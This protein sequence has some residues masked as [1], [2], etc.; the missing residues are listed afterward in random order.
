[1]V[2]HR[3]L[4]KTDA[5]GKVR[6][7]YMESEGP[8]YRTVSGLVDG[9]LTISAWTSAKPKNVGRSNATTAEQQ[10][11]LEVIAE[12]EKK[13]AQ[14]GYSKE[15]GAERED[16]P[17]PMLAQTYKPCQALDFASGVFVQPKLDG[18]RC[19]AD[20]N[21]LRTRN[22]KPITSCPH[23][24][25]VLAPVFDANPNIVFDGELYTHEHRDN[26][27]AIVS[28]VRKQQP[29]PESALIQYH[30]Y[31]HQSDAVFYE[32]FKS[33]Q[34][35]L[36]SCAPTI[37]IVATQHANSPDELDRLHGLC[38]E[39]G[40]EGSM[41]RL[42]RPYEHK[43]S[44]FLLKRKDFMT[45]E[46]TIVDILEGEGNRSRMAGKIVYQLGESTFESGI[47]GGVQF[48]QGLLRDK[49]K[50]IGCEGAVR[51]F[52]YTPDGVPRFPVTVAV[53]E[54]KRDA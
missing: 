31:D 17:E 28:A 47:K 54:G 15:L 36:G 1:M 40:Y 50:Y 53:Y 25:A 43:R 29:T 46:F 19:I 39:L 27:N 48:Y 34:R 38:V 8:K 4:Y 21:G 11:E 49:K 51:F 33:V 16:L 42:N 37:Q 26:F 52:N 20:R 9:H 32:R 30:V 7:W 10:A 5:K 24:V 6:V 18:I 22:G 14:G 23:V 2:K 12:Y 3:E 45:E 41:I 35:L 44:K 13:L